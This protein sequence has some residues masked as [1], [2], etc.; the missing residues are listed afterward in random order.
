MNKYI[1][2]IKITGTLT[3]PLDAQGNGGEGHRRNLGKPGS[4]VVASAAFYD[5]AK[6]A[7]GTSGGNFVKPENLSKYDI[8]FQGWS[9]GAA[10]SVCDPDVA[11]HRLGLNNAMKATIGRSL[12]MTNVFG[13][14]KGLFRA[15]RSTHGKG[16]MVS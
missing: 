13:N 16:Y 8:L 10:S 1:L 12:N 15:C 3:A 11:F 2:S 7:D 9:R 5:A 4:K 14:S 6:C